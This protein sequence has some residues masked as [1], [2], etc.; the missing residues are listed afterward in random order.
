MNGSKPVLH[1]VVF[2]RTLG[3]VEAVNRSDKVA[4]YA[5]DAVKTHGRIVLFAFDVLPIG[6][7]DKFSQPGILEGV[8]PLDV[9]F[10][11]RFGKVAVYLN[12]FT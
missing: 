1:P 6:S 2:L 9:Q 5:P 8:E 11:F 7:Q 12:Q 3:V 10:Q 4:R